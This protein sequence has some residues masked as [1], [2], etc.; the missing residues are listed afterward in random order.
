MM[1]LLMVHP[2]VIGG[3]GL[4]VEEPALTFHGGAGSSV[5]TL[6]GCAQ[7][8]ASRVSPC[9]MAAGRNRPRSPCVSQT[10]SSSQLLSGRDG[11]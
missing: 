10:R 7:A 2:P 4:I 9:W 8:S 6:T 11:A 5:Q 1:D 3:G